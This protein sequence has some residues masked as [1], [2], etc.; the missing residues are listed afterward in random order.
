MS[1][2]LSVQSFVSYGYVGHSAAMPALQALGVEVNA[3]HTTLLSSHPGYEGF[4][5]QRVD[6]A[7]FA[8]L[9]QALRVRHTH[10]PYDA[11]LWG[12]LAHAELAQQ[13]LA[14]ARALRAQT[15]GLRI[16]CDPV[17]GDQGRLYVHEG[18]VDF[19][20]EAIHDADVLLPNQDELTW[21]SQ[22]PAR[23]REAARQAA[24]ALAD[25]AQAIV[26]AKGLRLEEAPQRLGIWIID[27]ER[28]VFMEHDASPGDFAGCGDVFSALVCARMLSGE[29]SWE[30][31][32]WSA[33][34]LATLV[35]L[36]AQRGLDRLALPEWLMGLRADLTLEG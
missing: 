29:P 14:L 28:E 4:D 13:T 6:S 16:F 33:G 34:Q 23:T 2:L 8:R 11:M 3:L 25:H 15:P 27:H 32:S 31:A 5:G 7:L 19:Y 20:R 24:R 1:L 30:A 17:L 26:L 12:Y 22:R 21:L 18:L 9:A 35:R 36:T 10:H